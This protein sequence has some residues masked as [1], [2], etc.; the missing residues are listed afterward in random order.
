MLIL[1]NRDEAETNH[2]PLT[3]KL[4]ATSYRIRLELSHSHPRHGPG[5]RHGPQHDRHDRS[6]TVHPH[7][8]HDQRD[9]RAAGHARMDSRGP[10]R[11]LRWAGM[12]GVGRRNARLRRIVS[13]PEGNL[14]AA[15]NGSPHL[16][17]VH[18]AALLQRSTLHCYGMSRP[19]RIRRI[20]LAGLGHH[21]CRA[22][23]RTPHS[24]GRPVADKL[25]RDTRHLSSRSH[26]LLHNSP[27]LP[28]NHSDR[29]PLEA[30][31]DRRDGYDWLD[32]F[33]WDHTLQRRPG[34]RF[35][36]QRIPALS[37]TSYRPWRSH[38]DRDV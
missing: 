6:G 16:V 37:R 18:L 17:P 30:A 2:W 7:A 20:L 15:E 38:A 12:G 27:A 29:P 31:L 9:G 8:P 5:Q 19:G 13:L 1:V 34:V 10:V 28:S 3:T 22:Q 35:S 11:G 24:L 21:L 33:R 32:H 14:W 36:S 25:D 4:D 26:L 23:R